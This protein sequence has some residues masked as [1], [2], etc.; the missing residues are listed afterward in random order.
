[1]ND[2]EFKQQ[3]LD[4]KI[5]SNKLYLPKVEFYITNVCNLACEGC[6][7]FNNY[8]F[9]GYQKWE[10]LREIY[11][12]W[13]KEIKI[14]QISILGGEPLLNPD[15]MQWLSGIRN[16]WP[17]AVLRVTT[18]GYR[19]NMI[20]GLYQFML[21]HQH[22]TCISVGIHN[23]MHKELIIDKVKDFLQSPVQFEFDGQ[24]AYQ[25]YLNITDKNN[26]SIKV[27]YNWWFHQG[28]LIKNLDPAQFT[29][30]QSDVKKAHDICHSKTCHQFM[31]G[32]LY[33]CGAVALFP[34]FAKQ[35]EILLSPED[36][37]L[38]M[39]Y[40]PMTINDT[41]QQ[42]Q[43]FVNNLPNA[44]PQCRFCPDEYHG[45]QIYAEEK[46]VVFQR[47]KQYE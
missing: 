9:S 31:N 1:M 3:D 6:N 46:K 40:L 10:E 32:K 39:G 19:L 23:K 34:E 22:N 37:D 42:K 35:H 38:M 5:L 20:K 11:T 2:L 30:H 26:V 8:K 7:R 24:N 13:S 15:F 33:K 29:L 12:A 16:L 25:Q 44:I 18:N 14:H 47:N 17:T 21:D 45:K 27:E 36:Q 28:A 4:S 41:D 43:E